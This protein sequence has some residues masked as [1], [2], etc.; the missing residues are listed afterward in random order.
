[1]SCVFQRGGPLLRLQEWILRDR[2]MVVLQC[3]VCIVAAFGIF[4]R[5]EE[6]SRRERCTDTVGGWPGSPR[7]AR[8]VAVGRCNVSVI[9]VELL[10][11]FDSK[12]TCN[13]KGTCV[14]QRCR[15]WYQ[16]PTK[17]CLGPSAKASHTT[18]F[19][20][21]LPSLPFVAFPEHSPPFVHL[22]LTFE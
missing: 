16:Q 2:V 1:V 12:N 19:R 7:P 3:K 20:R 22:L 6:K 18:L 21:L 4:H 8:K 9:K 14:I 10:R 17:Y 15:Y 11:S 5:G 13:D